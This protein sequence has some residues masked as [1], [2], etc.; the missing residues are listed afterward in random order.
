MSTL[1]RRRWIEAAAALPAAARLGRAA[2]NSKLDAI[3]VQLYTVRDVVTQRPAET[4]EALE[5][6]GYREVE[7]IGGMLD[8]IWP[9]LRKTKL[10]PV[11]LH[12]NAA[13]FAEARAGD[14]AA[15]L[16]DA[17]E[18]G[19]EYVVYPF[20]APPERAGMEGMRKLAVRLNAAG[21]E[22]RRV[23]LRLCYHNHAFE[24]EPMG[25]ST[26]L[27]ALLRAT[28]PELVAL[29]MDV[30]WVSVAGHDPVELLGR[31]SGRVPLLHL[32]DKAKG[33]PRQFDEQVPKTTFKEAGRGSL[34]F[35]A[36]LRAASKAGVKHYFVEQ[37]A[38]P[39]DPVA[40]LRTSYEYLRALRF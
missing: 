16:R 11:S 33:A 15:A 31:Y 17:K 10:A 38:T 1:T 22:A 26:P 19:F 27:E 4:L 29:E 23:G 32:K 36:I 24:F 18:K 37:D 6:I 35:A 2:G 30:F 25:G 8:K 3:G 9:A 40:S 28:S 5:N 7:A 14:L 12:L 20:V 13:L 21:E 39:G 34:D